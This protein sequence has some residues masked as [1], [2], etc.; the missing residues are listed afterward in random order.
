[1]FFWGGKANAEGTDMAWESIRVKLR[2]II[3]AEDKDKPLR[4]DQIAKALREQGIT[5]ARRTVAKYRDL[6]EIP[7]AR[8]RR[9]F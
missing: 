2:E 3:D 9:T 5:I 8:K 6:M 7:P 4:D 1:M